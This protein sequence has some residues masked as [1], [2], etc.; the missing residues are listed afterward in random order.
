MQFKQK[1]DVAD[2]LTHDFKSFDCDNKSLNEFIKRYA[3]KNNKLGIS[4]TWVLPVEP[5]EPNKGQKLEIASYFTLTHH[6]VKRESLPNK[7]GSLPPYELPV[8]LLARLAVS[9]K[10]K[11]KGLG[12]KT[13][14][15]AL[16][17]SYTINQRGLP[18]IG[19]ILDVLDDKA[20][21]F[22]NHIGIFEQFSNDPMRLFVSM[23]IICDL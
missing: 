5:E 4:K 2:S 6:T 1:F 15:S 8:I 14:V 12:A 23:K 18:S 13:L 10:Y 21:E 16:R 3:E 7:T 9:N 11:G 20:K 22:Y 19:V 17:T